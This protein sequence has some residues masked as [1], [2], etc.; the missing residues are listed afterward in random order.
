[1][2]EK[3]LYNKELLDELAIKLAKFHALTPPLDKKKNWLSLSLSY[4]LEQIC[5]KKFVEQKKLLERY[6]CN[7]LLVCDVK[8][9]LQWIADKVIDFESPIVFC[10]NDFRMENT[11]LIEDNELILS[12]F[13]FSHYGYRGYD[14]AMFFNGFHK[15]VDNK[16]EFKDE[17]VVKQFIASYVKQC[18]QIYGTEYSVNEC[19][20]VEHILIETKCVSLAIYLFYLRVLVKYDTFLGMDEKQCLVINNFNFRN[21]EIFSRSFWQMKSWISI[22]CW[23]QHWSMKSYWLFNIEF[24]NLY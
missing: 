20:S 14:F 17:S 13:D 24:V 10:H 12:D 8:N 4:D 3:D 7:A 15:I 22:W 19:N 23:S 18:E 21:I 16:W 6:E 1:M 9:E 5:D 2:E 11:L